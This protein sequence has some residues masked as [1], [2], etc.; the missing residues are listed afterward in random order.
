MWE[1]QPTVILRKKNLVQCT[2]WRIIAAAKG[3]NS[4]GLYIR[5]YYFIILENI[6][7][8]I[9]MQVV[10]YKCIKILTPLKFK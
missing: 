3:I 1:Y 8:T 4:K 5:K 6:S 9:N 2:L 7:G 10:R